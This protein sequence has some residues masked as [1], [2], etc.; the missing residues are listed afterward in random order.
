M[1]HETMI[2]S[3][4]IQAEN[5]NQIKPEMDIDIILAEAYNICMGKTRKT[6]MSREILTSAVGIACNLLLSAAKLTV[7]CLFG[8]VS[9]IADGFNN[10]SDC[11]SSIVLLVSFYIS[12]KPA[13]KEH[14]YGH[15]RSEYIAAMVT[16]FFVLFLA[17][18][19]LRES[20]LKMIE[21]V[22]YSGSPAVYLILG[23]SVF[24]KAGLYF[25]DHLMSKKLNSDALKAA[26]TDS[27]C[28]CVATS[29]VIIGI[30]ILQF[31][32]FP[33]DGPAGIIV[34]FFIVWQGMKILIESSSKLLG[35]A[36]DH[37]LLT[38]IKDT[39]LAQ[40][41]VLG[42]HDLRVYSY[43][44]GV[45]FATVHIEMDAR[46][47]A[48]EA[49]AVIDG[50]EQQIKETLN[51]SLTAHLDPIDLQDKETRELEKKVRAAAEKSKFEIHDFRIVRG[52][53]D[54]VIFDV[55]V[56]YSCK[57]RDEEVR[58]EME[59]KIKSFGEYKTVITIDRQ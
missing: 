52:A 3:D 32:G 40:K 23:I 17:I 2:F 27:L 45:S 56:P 22:P 57:K 46:L 37:N 34:A 7:G 19:L 36:P 41:D 26:A 51:V 48:L 50:I 4:F 13:D 28:D 42:L 54:K 12:E 39:V 35:Q 9:V 15:R 47:P 14:P 31:T 25:Y 11:G 49:H 8:L 59:E 44:K 18:E 10:L 16:G 43:G 24:V 20:I 30:L 21:A 53:T 58:A 33:A 5:R 55:G 29:A 6:Q 38:K 1:S